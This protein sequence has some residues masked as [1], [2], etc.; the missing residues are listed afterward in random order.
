MTV[1][2]SFLGTAVVCFVAGAVLRDRVVNY[3][4]NI[5]NAVRGVKP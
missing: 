3:A 2:L 4:K 1:A 5:W